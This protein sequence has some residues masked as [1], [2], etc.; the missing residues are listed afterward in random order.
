MDEPRH[1][2]EATQTY[3]D[4]RQLLPEGITLKRLA[5]MLFDAPT[6]SVADM[7]H[8]LNSKQRTSTLAESQ[9][10]IETVLY[11]MDTMA[12]TIIGFLGDQK[13]GGFTSTT[14]AADRARVTVLQ[15]LYPE[16][17][18]V[19]MHTYINTVR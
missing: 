16:P 13:Q 14:A 6:T 17:K 7:F 9:D 19:T 3:R 12:R 11:G 1:L 8:A 10:T 18:V 5:Q 4:G 2:N 15:R